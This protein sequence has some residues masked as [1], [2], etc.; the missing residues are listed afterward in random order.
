MTSEGNWVDEGFGDTGEVYLV[1]SDGRTRSVSRPYLENPEAFLVELDATET[2][3]DQDR[4]AIA[5][6]GTTSVFLSVGDGR[7]L[8]EAVASGET[9]IERSNYLERPVLTGVAPVELESLEW[10]A[11]AE[12]EAEEI[13]GPISDFRRGLIITVAIFVISITF[14]TVAWA[15]G[16]FR[17]VRAIG[18]KMRRIHDGEALEEGEPV[19]SAPREFTDLANS[20]DTML[21]ALRQREAD[22]VQ[23]SVE[24][25]NTVRSLLP[26]AI[27][28]RVEAGDRNVID[29]VPQAGILV[30]V[31]D[32]LGEMVRD[33]DV[34]TTR[35]LLDR[36][37]EEIDSLALH[38]G[39]E[40]V[41]LVG[42][43]FFAGC[44]L[45]QPYLDHVPRSVAFALDARD[46]VR[47]L[48]AVYETSPG[49]A[50]GIHSGPVTVG[51]AG[52]ARLAYD[53]WGETVAAAHF[54]AR[55]ARPGEILVSET[56]RALLPPDIAAAQKETGPETPPVWEIVGQRDPEDSAS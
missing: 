54:L 51:L 14:V 8:A 37:V 47:E 50:A 48:A 45:T 24:R 7:E 22:L 28:E 46:A 56:V 1:A 40:R 53:L 29:Q 38:H 6:V 15:R 23:A 27:A 2:V 25:L 9:L 55:L 30:L 4:N 43:A 34:A 19:S 49:L 17:P 41:K 26:S 39:V 13:E 32:R 3:A 16:V 35:E 36:L 10:F 11:L 20:I 42:D 33:Q 5:G 31:F 44:G 21:D 52:S 12:F 18:D